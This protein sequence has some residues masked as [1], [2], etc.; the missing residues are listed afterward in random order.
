M[1]KC[2]AMPHPNRT[3]ANSGW[4]VYDYQKS[5]PTTTT[6]NKYKEWGT[7]IRKDT[8]PQGIEDAKRAM[9]NT[10]KHESAAMSSG[11]KQHLSD[12]GE[13]PPPRKQNRKTSGEK[14]AAEEKRAANM[15]DDEKKHAKALQAQQE[16]LQAARKIL[17]DV[18]K[19]ENDAEEA[20]MKLATLMSAGKLQMVSP[21]M[22]TALQGAAKVF[23]GQRS[24]I[25]NVI[26]SIDAESAQRTAA[27]KAKYQATMSSG[28]NIVK[29]F[30]N[31]ENGLHSQFVRALKLH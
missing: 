17:K 2:E 6:M 4:E 15:T 9:E 19:A 20:Q 14:R 1:S 27:H 25:N 16:L 30:M 10:Y 13:K 18:T 31:A 26:A 21:K 24:K 8:D 7:K 11:K 28:S 12:M 5:G 3:L 22:V 29:H 23:T